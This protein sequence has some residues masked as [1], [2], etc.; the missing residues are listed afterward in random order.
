LQSGIIL[1]HDLSNRKSQQNLNK[2]LAEV[3]NKDNTSSSKSLISG[4]D[5][6]DPE[7]FVGSTQVIVQ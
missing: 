5:A 6:Y 4:L 7:Q 1:V 3:L 2:W